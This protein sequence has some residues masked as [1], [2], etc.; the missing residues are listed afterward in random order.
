MSDKNLFRKMTVKKWIALLLK[1]LLVIVVMAF[2]GRE[3]LN[4]FTYMFPAEQWYMAYTGFGL[5]M[6]AMLVYL[7]LFLNDAETSLQKTVSILMV[8]FGIVGELTTAGFGM[9]IASWQKTGWTMTETD[10]NFMIL[11]VRI[12]M[13]IHA[14]A[15]IAY[16]FGDTVGEALRDDDKDG[17]PNYRDPDYKRPTS[18]NNATSSGFQRPQVTYSAEAE[19]PPTGSGRD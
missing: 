10:V 11:V 1:G 16:S 13:F 2:L 4:F 8:V 3:S 6:G 17:T 19:N 9:E 5:T 14:V 15:L 7:Y 18:Q 12:M